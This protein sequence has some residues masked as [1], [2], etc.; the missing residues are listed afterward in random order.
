MRH[1]LTNISLPASWEAGGDKWESRRTSDLR[2]WFSAD[3]DLL[4]VDSDLRKV[5]LLLAA[6]K[7]AR[8]R[9]RPMILLDAVLRPLTGWKRNMIR[10][11]L[12]DVS[13]FLHYFRDL[14]GYEEYYGIGPDRSGYVAFKPNL[15][16]RYSPSPSEG[17]Y[18]LCFGRSMRDYDTFF[19]AAEAL[20]IPCAIPAVKR[21]QLEQHC[22]RMTL[23]IPEKVR[24]L[25]D[26]GSQDS[27]IRLIEGAKVIALPILKRNICASGIGTYLN[28][29]LLGKCTIITDG[30]GV[31]EILTENQ[32]IIVPGE[33]PAELAE[34]V[35]AIWENDRLRLETAERGRTYAESLGGVPELMQRVL[36]ASMDWFYN[37]SRTHS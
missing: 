15:R 33:E 1:A 28:A 32:A 12:K 29:M 22:S 18:V 27:L 7:V 30:P 6:W 31:T 19:R 17:E 36:K 13:Y 34:A 14:R 4:I 21:E 16:Y 24:V 8:W 35:I 2:D 9:K 11:L 3:Y 5:L 37:S 26:D 23:V 10:W 25:D 20:N